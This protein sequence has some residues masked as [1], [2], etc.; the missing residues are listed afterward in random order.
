MVHKRTYTEKQESRNIEFVSEL[1]ELHHNKIY[2]IKV[3]SQYISFYTSYIFKYH[4]DL[5]KQIEDKMK[6]SKKVT[7]TF[8][9]EI[10]TVLHKTSQ[11]DVDKIF[12]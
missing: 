2:W 7:V 5:L 10:G 1:E 3:Q 9:K 6:K 4:D 11:Q 8:T 12:T